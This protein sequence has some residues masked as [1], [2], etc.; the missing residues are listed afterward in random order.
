MK[1]R[2]L[3]LL[4]TVLIVTVMICPNI[5]AVQKAPAPF[6]KPGNVHI[7]L[8][9]QMVEGEFMQ[10]LLAG[11]TKQAAQLGVKMTVFGKNMDN[12]AQANF[13]YQA[14]SMRVSGIMLDHGLTET[15]QKPAA[16]AIK[17]GI[18]VVAFDVDVKN[19]DIPQIAQDD[20]LL[21]KESL[22]S[23]I[24]TFHGK[25]NIGYVYVPGILPLDKRNVAYTDLLKKNAGIK[26]VARTGT[27]ESPFSVKN[28]DQAKAAL[29][30]HP[31]INAYF[32]PYDEFAKGV[33]MAATEL[34][35][36][37]KIYSADIST[38]DIELM[39]A[40][41]SPWVAT[42]ATNPSTIGAVLVRA[43]CRKI[44]GE[45]LPHDILIP[46]TLFTA[47]MLNKANVKNMDE[48]LKAFP[49]FDNKSICSAPW[50][51]VK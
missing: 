2:M 26:E 18:P 14:I 23:L 22:Q 12:E 5:S 43:I 9:R 35:R 39:R 48:L 36:N 50:I 46:P 40:K 24:T 28:A 25:A 49:K 21:G 4:M 31:E 17:A 16:D 27:L 42:C 38:Q 44:V 32:A 34:K 33:Y 15:L 3:F 13:V 1:K 19:P 37:I 11:A 10:N 51:P 20:Y 6:D 41:N 29:I 47:D 30:A 7:V 45:Q 8:I